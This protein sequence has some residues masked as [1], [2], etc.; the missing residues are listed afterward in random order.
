MKLISTLS[1]NLSETDKNTIV[2]PTESSI[3]LKESNTED[4]R[5]EKEIR[6]R[7]GHLND[8]EDDSENS[9]PKIYGCKKLSKTDRKEKKVLKLHKQGTINPSSQNCTPASN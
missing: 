1:E 5:K 4:K 3:T 8:I 2:L 7:Y 6:Q 9:I